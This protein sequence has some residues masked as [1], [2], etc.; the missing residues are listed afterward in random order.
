MLC[1]TWF[2]GN[3]CAK[4]KTFYE[5]DLQ[6]ASMLPGFHFKDNT[7]QCAK[8]CSPPF[9]TFTLIPSLF[10]LQL[11]SP[12]SLSN[13]FLIWKDRIH[14]LSP[15]H[16]SAPWDPRMLANTTSPSHALDTVFKSTCDV[17]T[18]WRGSCSTSLPFSYPDNGSDSQLPAPILQG[19]FC[20][21]VYFTKN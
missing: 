18:I 12:S 15:P 9:P 17:H 20:F 4:L 3:Y 10:W 8:L 13:R 21:T 2:K 14:S 1:T 19:Q 7:G 11:P 5:K 6:N 16:S